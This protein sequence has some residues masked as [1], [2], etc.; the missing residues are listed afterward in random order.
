MN[1]VNIKDKIYFKIFFYNF[2]FFNYLKVKISKCNIILTNK[3]NKYNKYIKYNN[4]ANIKG[5]AK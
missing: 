1:Y 4:D 3:Y 2:L 5:N